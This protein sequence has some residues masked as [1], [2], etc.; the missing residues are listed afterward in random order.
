MSKRLRAGAQGVAGGRGVA[1]RIAAVVVVAGSGLGAVGSSAQAGPRLAGPSVPA[2]NQVAAQVAGATARLAANLRLPHAGRPETLTHPDADHAGAQT[3]VGGVT[4]SGGPQPMAQA[5]TAQAAGSSPVGL[6]VSSYQGNVNWSQ[7]AANGAQFAFSKA[8]EG[9]YYTNPYFTQQYQ[10]AAGQGLIRG[11][12]HF[13]IPNNSSGAAQ[14]DYFVG[15]GGAWPADNN[16]L[17][18]VLDIEYNPYGATCY[19]LSQTQMV[20]WV[21]SFVNEYRTD[22]G[23]WPVI[24]TT[25]DWWTTCTGNSA[26]FAGQDPLWIANYSSSP[27]PLPS[28]WSF[29]TFWQYADS[30]VFPGDQDTFNGSTAQLATLAANVD[31]V[32]AYYQQLGGSGS[33][34]GNPVNNP[35]SV[36][37]G[38]EE[39]FSGGS[40]YWSQATGAH[41]VHGAILAHF[42]ALGGPG[43]FLGF[44]V[45]DEMVAPDGVGRFNHF[46]RDGSIY[47]TPS[48]GAWSVHG[49]VQDHWAALGWETSPVGYPVTD[50][51]VAPDGVG[52]F[53]HFSRDG[54]I[55]WTPSTGAW[56]V[57]GAIQDK[58]ASL[59]WERSAVGYPTSDEYA[60]TGGRRNNFVSGTITWNATTKATTFKVS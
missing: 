21:A 3:P 54:S 34:L 1:A 27:A 6:D 26:S 19:G 30:G 53:N 58:W 59:G 25:T 51:M 35:Y 10:G 57:H 24:Y 33:Y 16:T 56:S 49:A 39:D 60:I 47:W 48:T 14:A 42:Q 12:Y 22:T 13:A 55:Y 32:T 37:G 50:E 31:P 18:G 4:G 20:S 52:R 36:A 2:P 44:P 17:P 11:A 9:T 28:G 5:A 38:E 7:V 23:R 43:G 41:A 45:T 29:Y 8:T 46:S 15:N 40:I